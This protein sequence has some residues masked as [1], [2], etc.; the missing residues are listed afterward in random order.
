MEKPKTLFEVLGVSRR[1][2]DERVQ[3]RWRAHVA[4]ARGEDRVSDTVRH[5]YRVLANSAA[6]R[7]Y[8]DLLKACERETP[9]LIDPQK[10]KGIRNFCAVVGISLTM[11]PENAGWHHFRLPHQDPIQW[12]SAV[13]SRSWLARL[14]AGLRAL[15]TF[16]VFAGKSAGAQFLLVLAY[17]AVLMSASVATRWLGDVVREHRL[18]SLEAEV[19]VLHARASD[20]YRGLESAHKQFGEDFRSIAGVN[21]DDQEPSHRPHDLDFALIRHESVRVGWYRLHEIEPSPASFSQPQDFLDAVDSRIRVSTF[22]EADRDRLQELIARISADR[23][24]TDEQRQ[25]LTH[26]KAMITGDRFESVESVAFP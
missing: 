17:I 14:L 24:A 5:A 3:R 25:W 26:I 21:L 22:L 12:P 8:R 2:T 16:R 9:I 4:K 7:Q 19:R 10:A 1:A 6:R 13:V 11:D 15:L 20:A 23:M 18:R